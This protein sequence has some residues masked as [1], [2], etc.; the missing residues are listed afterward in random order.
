VVLDALLDIDR[1]D[2][3]GERAQDGCSH[4][5]MDRGAL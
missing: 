1:A 5:G 4:D 2:Y 3:C